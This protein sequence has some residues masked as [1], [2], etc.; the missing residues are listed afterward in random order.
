MVTESLAGELWQD[1]GHAI[2]ERI[3]DAVDI[4]ARHSPWREVVGV[5]EDIHDNGADQPAV[6][7][8]FWPVMMI[9]FWE[10]PT[11]VTRSVA[12]VIRSPRAGSESLLREIRSAIWAGNPTLPWAS[13]RT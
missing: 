11:F 7:I 13:I 1:P 12:I 2:D 5:V 9:D 6:A 10:N 4:E 8:V 3:R